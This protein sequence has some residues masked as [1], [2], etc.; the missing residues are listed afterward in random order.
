[1]ALLTGLA[2]GEAYLNI[3]TTL[4]PN[5]EI[6]GFLA[7]VPGP[8]VSAGLPGPILAGGVLFGWGRRRQK[9]A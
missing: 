7:P 2:A 6:R 9:V 1:M 8:V 4:F 3:H 5:G